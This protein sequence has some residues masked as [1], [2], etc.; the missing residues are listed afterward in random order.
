[1]DR[2]GI[3]RRVHP[4]SVHVT[5]MGVGSA[6][7][8]LTTGIQTIPSGAGRGGGASLSTV[9][10][11]TPLAVE[12]AG[13]TSGVVPSGARA[14]IAHATILTIVITA[15]TTRDFQLF[16]FAT[17]IISLQPFGAVHA[18]LLHDITAGESTPLEE[19]VP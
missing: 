2:P 13:I 19:A 15:M 7:R 3:I 11:K 18:G 4:H 1:M 9:G 6:H 10:W 16:V 14:T 12:G 17:R 5:A 8:N